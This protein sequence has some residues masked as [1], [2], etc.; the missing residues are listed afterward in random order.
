MGTLDFGVSLAKQYVL[1]L[2]EKDL[3]SYYSADFNVFMRSIEKEEQPASPNNLKK[4]NP[5]QQKK[6]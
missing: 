6:S 5:K 2:G 1:S 3:C 4:K